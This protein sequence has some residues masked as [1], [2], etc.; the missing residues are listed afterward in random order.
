MAVHLRGGDCFISGLTFARECS[1]SQGRQSGRI[2]AA[3]R[4]EKLHQPAIN[5]RCQSLLSPICG[6]LI[7]SRD[8]SCWCANV[9]IWNGNSGLFRIHLCRPYRSCL[10]SIELVC[11]HVDCRGVYKGVSTHQLVSFTTPTRATCRISLRQI[12]LSTTVMAV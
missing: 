10:P 6:A 3:G 11:E 2:S 8:S 1:G 4:L 9:L 12:E 7:R 5:H